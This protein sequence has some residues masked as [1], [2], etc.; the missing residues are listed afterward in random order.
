MMAI[1]AFVRELARLAR[2]GWDRA[3]SQPS[4]EEP[5]VH[6][7]Q[8]TAALQLRKHAMNHID[9]NLPYRHVRHAAF[10]LALGLVG[11]VPAH[12]AS[13]VWAS[14]SNVR[15]ENSSEGPFAGSSSKTTQSDEHSLSGDLSS[16]AVSASVTGANS[17]VQ[18]S[19]VISVY[20]AFS[21][22][23]CG[24]T[25][26][27]TTF[28]GA[29]AGRW[30]DQWTLGSGSSG[31]SGTPALVSVTFEIKGAITSDRDLSFDAWQAAK[32]SLAHAILTTHGTTPAS[33]TIGAD[34]KNDLQIKSFSVDIPMT[35]DDPLGLTLALTTT[36]PG[37][38]GI[39]F[40]DGSESF[41]ASIT[42]VRVPLGATLSHSLSGLHVVAVPEPATWLMLV[43]GLAA[44]RRAKSSA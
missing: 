13:S 30:G 34:F 39:G 14:A 8:R 7:H 23:D 17:Q 18:P 22:K 16:L 24:G 21:F 12:A 42:G 33:V 20:D 36:N 37:L 32:F 44:L 28:D 10:V 31:L 3:P 43:A 11:A 38:S 15:T 35:Y 41:E 26:C 9:L 4:A 25:F 1:N 27:A 2:S 40:I 19:G 5:A 6:V 29:A